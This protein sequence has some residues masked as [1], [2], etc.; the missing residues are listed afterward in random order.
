MQSE[1]KPLN[2]VCPQSFVHSERKQVIFK[3]K[4]QQAF[5]TPIEEEGTDQNVI[6]MQQK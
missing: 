2:V 5:R 1:N 3:R 6:L 4:T